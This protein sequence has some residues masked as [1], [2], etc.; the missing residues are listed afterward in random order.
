MPLPWDD[1][2]VGPNL[3]TLSRLRSGDKL[4]VLSSNANPGVA[5]FQ[6]LGK[7]NRG[8]RHRFD[9]QKGGFWKLKQALERGKKGENILEDN[10]YLTPISRIFDRARALFIAGQQGIQLTA[11]KNAYNGIGNMLMTYKNE[12]DNAA[13]MKVIAIQQ[14]ISPMIPT[15]GDRNVIVLRR[16]SQILDLFQ[17][18]RIWPD[19]NGTV[20]QFLDVSTNANVNTDEGIG[21]VP[22]TALNVT[23][24]VIQQV[25]LETPAM[26]R[27]SERTILPTMTASYVRQ[28]LG[29]CKQFLQDWLRHPPI[30]DGEE[31]GRNWGDLRKLFMALASDE[32]MFFLVSQ[33]TCQAGVE[34][35]H[36]S[37][38][39]HRNRQNHRNG[40]LWE[41][42]L[43]YNDY[44]WFPVITTSR[45][46]HINT[47]SEDIEIKVV[48]SSL[49]PMNKCTAMNTHPLTG[50]PPPV[51]D[52]S[53]S[54]PVQSVKTTI[55]VSLRRRSDRITMRLT[56]FSVEATCS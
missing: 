2:N 44:Y 39:G 28:G 46:T 53:T 19:L 43:F 35:L 8:L 7:G 18:A 30:L 37:I 40:G 5:Q 24:G 23:Q 22:L 10:Q 27:I 16:G 25:I 11:I 17:Y 12:N 29:V 34:S 54:P 45:D 9:I 50:Q 21:V 41:S 51:I 42:S 6:N 55:A 32:G 14:L 13:V 15:E 48:S 31:M 33:L 56:K 20:I 47:Q 36:S 1:V 3:L 52:M 26:F 38:F 4:S 49:P